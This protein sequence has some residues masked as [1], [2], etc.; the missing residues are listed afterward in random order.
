MFLGTMHFV[1]L[2]MLVGERPLSRC[3]STAPAYPPLSLYIN[4]EFFFWLKM[5]RSDNAI[6]HTLAKCSRDSVVALLDK[7]S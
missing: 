5:V 6:L 3:S 7:Y 4:V 2:L 1:K